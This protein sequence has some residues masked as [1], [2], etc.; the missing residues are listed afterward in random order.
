M[1]FFLFSIPSPLGDHDK[2][3]AYRN[4]RGYLEMTHIEIFEMIIIIY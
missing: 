1:I 4:K 2:I 3:D